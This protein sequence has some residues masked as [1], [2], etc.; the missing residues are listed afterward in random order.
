[1]KAFVTGAGGYIGTYLV[2]ALLER[3]H[4]VR[5]LVKNP[6]RL[7]NLTDLGVEAVSG[8]VRHPESLK[9]LFEGADVVFHL[10][11]ILIGSEKE[12]FLTNVEGTKNAAEAAFATG[13]GKFVLASSGTVYGDYGDQVVTEQA[14]CRPSIAYGISKLEAE[15]IVGETAGDALPH[16][17]CRL[18]G[19]YGP[20][21]QMLMLQSGGRMH[22]RFLG[23]GENWISPIH[24]EDAAE[25]L[26]A[27][28]ER[29][30][31]GEIY[32]LVDDE[33]VRLKEFYGYFA[34][35]L[36]ESEAKHISEATARRIARI[37]G[38]FGRITGKTIVFNADF[39]KMV[40]S[41]LRLSNEKMRKELG[42]ALK[43]PNFRVG[44]DSILKELRASAQAI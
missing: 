35:Q 13:V 38:F 3:G 20:R 29:G 16:V 23:E 31:S 41:S 6:A 40:F 44:I 39:V 22:V 8:D 11:G 14:E 9:G 37:A 24:V 5:G 18:G 17:V 15:R 32:N 12:M 26:I 10:V 21:S 43:Y 7:R 4:A 34:Y 36:G 2:R 42:V 30:Q 1:M 27:A 19:V 33:P 25:A 28:A